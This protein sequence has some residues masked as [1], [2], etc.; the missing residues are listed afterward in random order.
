MCCFCAGPQWDAEARRSLRAVLPQKMVD[1]LSA[2]NDPRNG[3]A[4]GSDWMRQAAAKCYV[5]SGP[6]R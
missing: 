4:G 6:P 3:A 1:A 2:R 5:H